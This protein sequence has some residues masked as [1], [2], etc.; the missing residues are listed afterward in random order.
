MKY[1]WLKKEG[2][3]ISLESRSRVRSKD[4]EGLAGKQGPISECSLEEEGKREEVVWK[5]MV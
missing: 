3:F 1:G 5:K 2:V 4:K